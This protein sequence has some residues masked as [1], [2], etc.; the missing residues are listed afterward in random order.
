MRNRQDPFAVFAVPALQEFFPSEC[1]RILLQFG[2]GMRYLQTPFHIFYCIDSY[3]HDTSPNKAIA[4]L[5]R[6]VI[7][8]PRPWPGTVV[9]LKLVDVAVPEYTNIESGDL[10]H[11]REYFAYCN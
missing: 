7:P 5:T 4:K 1:G 2:T 8:P 11:I 9:V 6:G 3:V 10:L